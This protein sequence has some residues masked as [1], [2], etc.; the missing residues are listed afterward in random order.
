MA[1]EFVM[2]DNRKL[3]ISKLCAQKYYRYIHSLMFGKH[4]NYVLFTV[5]RTMMYCV[6]QLN[7]LEFVM[8]ELE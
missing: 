7:R 5:L 4:L 3:G 1:K 8:N 2:F 6:L